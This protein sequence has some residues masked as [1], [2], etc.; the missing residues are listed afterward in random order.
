[1][2]AGL[3]GP[4]ALLAGQPANAPS[5][6]ARPP[7]SARASRVGIACGGRR[8]R[9]TTACGGA[10]R[11]RSGAKRT[12]R[13]GRR[14]DQSGE[15]TAAKT[16]DGDSAAK[17]ARR[18]QRGRGRGPEDEDGRRQRVA[19]PHERRRH[20]GPVID[21]VVP[22]AKQPPT[23][24]PPDVPPTPQQEKIGKSVCASGWAQAIGH[25]APSLQQPPPRRRF[26][27]PSNHGARGVFY[28]ET[29]KRLSIGTRGAAQPRYELFVG[30]PSK[31][32]RLKI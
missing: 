1:M 21:L 24:A 30:H 16:A 3:A 2:R 20:V 9:P 8:G 28:C 10:Q 25:R 5:R 29:I 22:A 6:L 26:G 11:E 4:S 14:R 12:A 18:G 13:R 23:P 7:E 19:E 32:D 15:H 17:T 27:A 31:M